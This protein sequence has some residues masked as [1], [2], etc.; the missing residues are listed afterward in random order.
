MRTLLLLL[1]ILV[2][3]GSL[4]PFG[5]RADDASWPHF[6]E[7]ITDWSIRTSRG[8]F[9][10]NILLFGPIGFVGLLASRLDGE[11]R[12]P[13][14]LTMT[15][16]LLLAFALQVAQLWI[17][18]RSPEVG[19]A[20]IN[21]LGL[22]FGIGAARVILRLNL[23]T[24]SR[25]HSNTLVVPLLLALL[26]VG[27]L[28][29]PL[30]PTLD[31]QNVK[32]GLK[33]L[34]IAPAIDPTR[35][36][37]N[38]AGWIA[39]LLIL[40]RSRL[41]GLGALA[42]CMAAAFVVAMQP[43]FVNNSISGNN[44]VGLAIALMLLPALRHRAAIA[45]VAVLLMVAVL[46]SGLYPYRFSPWT[47]SFEWLPFVGFLRGSME[48]NVASLLYKC[49]FYGSILY[50]IHMIGGTWRTSA[51]TLAIWLALI[52]ALQIH[53]IGRTAELTDPLL[54]LILGYAF[55]RLP[56]PSQPRVEKHGRE[57]TP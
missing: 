10:A 27:Y 7:F 55:S 46:A 19:D 18:G 36:L 31:L 12:V 5:F 20:L 45:G 33:P 56:P 25:N 4:Y 35:V 40:T 57:C 16:A 9:I 15:L 13:L 22:A 53:V 34:L 51:V 38:A 43:L 50:L 37:I 44:V 47:N 54:A 21:T 49:Y 29:F 42:T 2:T 39:W 11:R 3:Y 32:N 30:V 48:G 26:W 1:A 52:E 6:L 28:W 14:R 23:S 24:A 8:D 17:P 41:P